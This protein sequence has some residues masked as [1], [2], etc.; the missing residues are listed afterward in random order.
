M[1]FA[2]IKING[3]FLTI[4]IYLFVIASHLSFASQ[5]PI[6]LKEDF[7]IGFWYIASYETY[8]R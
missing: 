6:E 8:E 3:C 2:Y 4:I 1:M 7:K 5:T